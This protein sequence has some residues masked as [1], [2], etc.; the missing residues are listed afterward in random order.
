MIAAISTVAVF[1][2]ASGVFAADAITPDRVTELV[3]ESRLA[4]DLPVVTLSSELS[5]A[6]SM[7]AEDMFAKQYFAHDTPDGHDPWYWVKKAGY[8]YQL[9]GENLAIHFR[10]AFSQHTAW[11]ESPTHRKNI[12]NPEYRDIGV[13]VR[14]GEYEGNPTTIVVQ[15]FGTK[16]GAVIDP[17]PAKTVPEPVRV[18]EVASQSAANPQASSAPSPVRPD[19]VAAISIAASVAVFFVMLPLLVTSFA[20]CQRAMASVMILRREQAAEGEN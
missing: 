17:A 15:F 10:D 20:F 8:T 11:M 18:G 12:L 4:R 5:A 14:S 16:K 3:N 6:A 19:M 2:V 9:A 7:K 13:A 1:G